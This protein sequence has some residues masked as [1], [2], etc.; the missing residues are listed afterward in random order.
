M[1]FRD[2]RLLISGVGQHAVTKLA[3]H[4]G[5][6]AWIALFYYAPQRWP[7]FPAQPAPTLALDQWVPFQPAWALVY[8]SVFIVHTLA[9]WLPRDAAAVKRYSRNV[10]AVFA[11]GALF[12]WLAPTISPRPAES[13]SFLHHWLI[14]AVDG[15]RNAFPSLHAAMGLLA[16]I[17]VGSHVRACRVS[18][19]WRAVLA[20]W[21]IAMLYS[22][23]ATRQ[24][25]LLDLL[26]GTLLGLLSFALPSFTT[27]PIQRHAP[28]PAS[29]DP[30][31]VP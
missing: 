12:F 26:A 23:L 6:G 8:Q 30:S 28:R 24:H 3:C 9:F 31:P 14:A 21:W 29:P 25:R 19:W 10:A 22:T 11:C 1:I 15:P 2:L 13:E 16:T 7:I 5:V 18:L 20:L 4:A 27:H 17:A